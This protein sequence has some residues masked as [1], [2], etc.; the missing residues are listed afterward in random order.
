[1]NSAQKIDHL[2]K[3]LTGF[4]GAFAAISAM[5]GVINVLALTGS[6]YML[7]VYDRV[8]TSHSVATLIALSLLAIGLY[9]FQGTLDV[10][11]S[12]VLVRLGSHLDTQLTPLVHAVAVRAPLR[13]ASRAE[14]LQPL[15]DVDAMRMFLVS[16]GPVA[17]FD[18]PW[19]PV[20]LVFVFLMHPLLGVTALAGAAILVALTFLTERL[21]GDL[22]QATAKSAVA[23]MTIADA[24]VRNAEVLSAMGMG[25]R[26]VE[27]Y[28]R[29]NAQYLANQAR[30]SDIAGSLSGV[31]KVLRMILQSA[32]LGMGAY[33]AIRGQ[34]TGG[35]IIA[36]SIASSRALAP[37]ELAITH[38][39]SFV[40]ARQSYARLRKVLNGPLVAGN[41]PLQLPPPA[42]NVALEGVTV[43]IPGTHRVV[44][45]DIS[46]ELKAGEGL[47]VIG[48]SAAGKSTL[49]RALIGLWP[50]ARG[51]VRLDGAALDRWSREE[52]G[53]HVGYLPQDVEL[54]EGSIAENI[55][56]FEENPESGI[57]IA[58]ARAA[59]VHELI[60]RLPN[61]YET[62]AGADGASLSAGQRQRI[63]L[64]RALYR[65]PFLVVLDEP[66]SNLDAE[67]EAALT[68]AIQGVRARGGIAV[69]IAQ[70]P[71]ALNA[72]DHIAVIA[73]G[74]LQAFDAKEKVLRK[75]MRR[76]LSSV[77]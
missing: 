40:A 75:A 70:R 51:E 62:Q 32:I 72:V 33:L 55:S 22:Q 76:P 13:G 14:S 48:R 61:G 3:A 68:A 27:R 7:Q 12:Q 63:A 57:I 37:I 24:N 73:D 23:R 29:A 54:F 26:A 65:D 58:A 60:L 11:R 21:T 9:L 52:L 45:A 74:R 2:D 64:A 43:A 59:G 17:I 42:S 69:V 49:A 18:L 6:F 10:L 47:G 28:A 19:M 67:G 5:S 71:S 34:M 39:K 25:P 66:N 38:W 8:L 50:L 30:A 31:S 41:D 15:R 20:Y 16:Q 53:R 77:S 1:M 46:F 36:A 35:A 56:R 4:R 44:L